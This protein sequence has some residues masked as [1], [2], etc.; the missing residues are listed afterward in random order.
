MC[1]AFA[2]MKE[3]AGKP[4]V[5]FSMLPMA[6]VWN[7]FVVFHMFMMV[8]WDPHRKYR[9]YAS[10]GKDTEEVARSKEVRCSYCGGVYYKGTVT[11]C[12]HCGAPLEMDAALQPETSATEWDDSSRKKS[13][14][15][16]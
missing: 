7:L 1:I 4:F 10:C 8:F 13:G 3:N 12:P 6:V 15:D 14:F 16:W 2:N 11:S 9:N 5:D